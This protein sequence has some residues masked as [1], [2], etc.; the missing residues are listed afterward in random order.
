[1]NKDRQVVGI[2][3]IFILL[4][5]SLGMMFCYVSSERAPFSIKII[6]NLL[7]IIN[8]L[9]LLYFLYRFLKWLIN[10]FINKR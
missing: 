9:C 2:F 7:G 5:I 10:K 4:M 6:I 3:I 8:L 1:M